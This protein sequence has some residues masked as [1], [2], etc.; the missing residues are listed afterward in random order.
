MIPL[1]KSAS[2]AYDFYSVPDGI[3]E[4][5]YLR[6]AP[7]DLTITYYFI[8]PEDGMEKFAEPDA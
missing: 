1:E 3:Y 5:S 4:T 2:H 8:A 6:G 7:T